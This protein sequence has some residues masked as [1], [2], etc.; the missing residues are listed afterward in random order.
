[1]II[2]RERKK[3]GREVL[4]KEEEDS[5]KALKTVKTVK[6]ENAEGKEAKT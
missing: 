2:A 6:A 5:V 4:R 1:M 3:R